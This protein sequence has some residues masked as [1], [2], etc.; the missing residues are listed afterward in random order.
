MPAGDAGIDTAAV[1]AAL[2]VR[3]PRHMVPG[4]YAVLPRLPLTVNGKLDR[5]ALPD[6]E[7]VAASRPPRTPLE[8]SLCGVFA[9][10]LGVPEVGADDDFFALGG[11]SL[12]AMRLV[13]RIRTVL[14]V[15][16]AVA[17]VLAAPTVAALAPVVDDAPADAGTGTG[18]FDPVLVLRPGDGTPVFCLPATTGLSWNYAGLAEH[19]PADV[20]LYG[21]QSPRLGGAGVPAASVAEL[22]RRYAARIRA[23][24]PDGPYRLLGWSYGGQLAHA[25]ATAL[26]ADGREVALLALLDAY[27]RDDTDPADVTEADAARFLLRLAGH[28]GAPAASLADAVAVI[29]AGEGPMSAFDAAT[30]RRIADTVHESVTLPLDF[31]VFDG[32]AV[33]FT[34]AAESAEGADAALSPSLWAPHLTGAVREHP[35]DCLHDDMLAPAPLREIGAVVADLLG[36]DR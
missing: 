3:L 26:Q 24:Q 19:L 15:R 35:I 9:D 11:H 29:A 31:G 14:G 12:L 22:G 1:R 34:A 6:P 17:D 8:A 2:A 25:V 13:G 23:V 33:C 5:R 21:L 10:V 36:G 18:P 4:A 7:P 20:P 32:D 28:A 27:P 30:L 16:V